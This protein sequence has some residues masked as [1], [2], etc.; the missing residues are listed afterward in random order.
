MTYFGSHCSCMT[1]MYWYTFY[2]LYF[3]TVSYMYRYMSYMY[4]YKYALHVQA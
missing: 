2:A 4:R 1:Y 3:R